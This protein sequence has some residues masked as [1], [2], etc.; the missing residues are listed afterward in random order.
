MKQILVMSSCAV[1]L[2]ACAPKSPAPASEAAAAPPFHVVTNVKQTMNWIIEPNADVLWD[3]VGTII[4]EKGREE[5]LPQ[6]EEEWEAVRGAAAVI[7]ESGN[8][9]MM[10]GRAFDRDE[11]MKA[12]RGMIDA[13]NT[14][15]AAAE[16]KDVPALFDA[17][18]AVYESCTGCH[19]KY[20]LA[21]QR[22]DDKP[23]AE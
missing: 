11:W 16:A 23:L 22:T 17:G 20:A 10:D 2:C 4:T 15:I 13:A 19:S 14:A 6:T 8:L 18:G 9:L 1:L 12:S 7:A 21:L 3:S 5:L